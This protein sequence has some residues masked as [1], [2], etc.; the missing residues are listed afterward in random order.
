MEEKISFG[1]FIIKK[2]KEVNLTQKE[3]A[4]KLYVTESAVSKWE[5]GISYPDITL[6][7]AICEALQISEHELLTASDDY[8]QKEI[9]RQAKS[10]RN[11]VR[12]YS[13]TFYL[14]YGI[15]LV[16]CFICN[17]AV[18]HELSWFF[19]V[20]TA[21]MIAFSL[22]NIPVLVKKHRG[23]ITLGTFYLS[24][25]LLLFTCC[26]YTGGDWFFIAFISILFAFVVVFLPFVLRDLET[27][28]IKKTLGK[29]LLLRHKSLLCIILDT[30]LL[31]L[32]L[33]VSC[34]YTGNGSSFAAIAL[35]VALFSILLPWVF[36]LVIR[37]IKING[38]F[39]TAI[40]LFTS[41]IYIFF[42]N[43]V[44][45][46]IIDHESFRM[47]K[48]NLSNWTQ[49]YINGNILLLT[50]IICV[51]M[52]VLFAIGGILLEVKRVGKN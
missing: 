24:L 51:G 29:E 3:L 36:L 13:W 45:N 19:I 33:A 35:P 39:K 26:I 31:F 52:A 8:Q 15:S 16:T 47:P 14:L 23:S 44:L 34:A 43:S 32:L 22:T 11:I 37:Y 40:C 27:V 42:V 6:V 10:F 46:V 30:L 49:N 12:T 17:I 5:R 2:R 1:K 18:N 38:L 28:F 9:E 7:A 41:G 50:T 48:Y 25:N 20:L 21:E 4:E